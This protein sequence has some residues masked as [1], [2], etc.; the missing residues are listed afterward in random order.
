MER[1]KIK[2]CKLL[3]IILFCSFVLLLGSFSSQKAQAS[4]KYPYMIK[5]NKKMNTVT[6]Y[7]QDSKGKYTKP[8][9]AMVCSTGA[10]TP[11]GTFRTPVKY[12]WKILSH[13]VWGQY[14]TR[15]TGSILFHSVWYYEKDPSTLSIKQYNRLGT[16]ASAGC[17]RL[18]TADAK[19]IYDNCPV[20]TTV[21]IYNSSNPGPLG[22]PSAIKVNTYSWDPSDKWSKSNPWNSKKPSITGTSNKTVLAGNSL[23]LKDKVKAYDT[24][25]NN[26]TSKLKIDTSKLNLKKAGTYKVTYSVTDAI[27][28]KVTKTIKVKVVAPEKV[29]FKGVNNK[30]LSYNSYKNKKLNDYVMNGV[31]AY[32]EKHKIDNNKISYKSQLIKNDSQAKVYKITYSVK[33][34]GSKKKTTKTITITLDKKGPAINCSTLYLTT[35]VYNTFRQELKKNQYKHV[36]VKDNTTKSEKIK[37]SNKVTKVSDNVYR[38]TYTATDSVNNKSIA[39]QT[40]NVLKNP[41]LAVKKEVVTV[42]SVSDIQK[43]AVE[44][45]MVKAS[46][47]DF[48]SHFKSEIKVNVQTVIENESYKVTYTLKV[49]GKT[50]THTAVYQI[51]D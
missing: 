6:V 32:A 16:Q 40:V 39:N 2:N 22:K 5:V 48:T 3:R 30:V 25:G 12:R 36:T 29:T 31:S 28:K 9:K 35:D 51:Q 23:N 37:V 42:A 4:S 44:N 27:N 33:N 1:I 13:S 8:V 17:V 34:P 43:H 7:K 38:V 46:G 49:C 50:I 24:C 10:D 47:K 11:L 20:G 18:T 19:W 26:I 15:I 21:T 14:S 45:V 41:V